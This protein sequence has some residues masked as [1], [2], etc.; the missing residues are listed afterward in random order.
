MSRAIFLKYEYGHKFVLFKTY[1]VFPFPERRSPKSYRTRHLAGCHTSTFQSHLLSR[2]PQLVLSYMQ[3]RGLP[4][5]RVCFPISVLSPVLLSQ[6]GNLTPRFPEQV[7][8][9]SLWALHEAQGLTI[10]LLSPFTR[11]HRPL[12]TQVL[13]GASQCTSVH[14]SYQH[15]HAWAVLSNGTRAKARKK[16]SPEVDNP[17][18]EADLK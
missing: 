13:K 16:C 14:S 17:A 11:T 7:S 18:G 9:S 6:P 5:P 3:L 10:C 12:G 4:K 1:G 15:L 8:P 2:L